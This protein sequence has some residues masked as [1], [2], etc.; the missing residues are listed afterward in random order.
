MNKKPSNSKKRKRE[1]NQLPSRKKSKIATFNW[2]D[3]EFQP[4]PLSM[5]SPSYVPV[6]SLEWDAFKYIE[7]YLDEEI[8]QL[9]VDK[10]NQ[11]SVKNSGKPLLTLVDFKKWLGM[12]FVMAAVQYPQLR[13][14]WMK[15]WKVPL[16]ANTM[17]REK[18]LIIRRSLKVVYDDD[19]SQDTQQADRLWKIRPLV[20][21]IRSGCLKQARTE[22]ICIDEM[23]IPFSGRTH[24]KQY[25]PNKPN[26]VGLKA[27][28][29]ANPNGV[30]CDFE[31]FQGSNSFQDEKAAGFSS[32]EGAILCLTR[33]LVP[34]HKIYFDRL[35][36]TVKLAD[37]LLDRGFRSTGTLAK[38]Y[39]PNNPLKSDKDIK[40]EGRGAIDVK[41]REDNKICVVKWQDNKSVMM[42]SSNEGKE[43]VNTVRRWSKSEKKYITVTQPNVIKAY[44]TY[45]GG[46]DMADRMLSY[47]SSRQRT[48]KWTTR[49]IMHLLDLAISNAW[50]CYREDKIRANIPLKKITQ[51][52]KYKM[53]YGEYL[54]ESSSILSDSEGS[55]YLP[56]EEGTPGRNSREL[57]S[58]RFRTHGNHLP[59]IT[60]G[61]QQRCKNKSCSKK[62]SVICTKCKV[63]LCLVAQRNCYLN[64]H[65]K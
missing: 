60:P 36:N 53:D 17:P 14:Y 50:L 1:P 3:A 56:E 15:K 25:V 22:H 51:L 38:R 18:F 13:M 58:I 8:L 5:V 45:M 26:P 64:Y 33:S 29:L 4:E 21:K 48:R 12:S 49:T 31:I 39:L 16:I 43:P 32:M 44:N 41:V 7:Q 9:I 37:E 2:K 35:F 61:I 19:I 65:K 46:V 42:L 54:I 11:T 63:H 28:V 57:P 30:V 20:D 55:E 47:C 6:S 52:R 24:L 23:M 34:G 10:T 59:E 27:F 40:Q 62:T